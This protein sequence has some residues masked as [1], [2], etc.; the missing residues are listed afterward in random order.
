MNAGAALSSDAIAALAISAE[1]HE[2]VHQGRR[3]CWRRFGDGPPLVLLHGGHGSWLHWVRNVQALAA[4]HTLW[5]PDMPGFGDSEPLACEPHAPERLQFLVDALMASLDTLVGRGAVIN[6]AGFSFGGLVAARLAALRG[7]VRRLA[8][9]GPAGHGGRRRQVQALREWRLGDAAEQAAALRFNLGSF[10][11]HGPAA[12]DEQALQ[13][14]SLCCRQTRFRS[15]SISLQG[16]LPATLRELQ[17]PTLLLWG[18]HDVTAEPEQIAPLL[19]AGQPAHAWR[20]L[21]GAGHW[22]QYE[23]ADAINALLADWFGAAPPTPKQP[24]SAAPG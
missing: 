20:V 22:V 23:S 10:M 14:H 5:L 19:V 16:L 24:T 6:L 8:L 15:R 17:Q 1:R 2:R 13:V 18:E 7:D 11:L 9:L 3:L 4:T 21:P 12:D